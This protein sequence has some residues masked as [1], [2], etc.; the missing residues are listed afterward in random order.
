MIYLIYATTLEEQ[1]KVL[2]QREPSQDCNLCPRLV[3]F[4]ERN[5]VIYPDFHNAPV[6]TWIPDMRHGDINSGDVSKVE[7]MIIGL[8]PGLKGANCTG[9][10]F[11]G[12]FA[13][14]L[15]YETLV[16]FGFAHGEYGAHPNDGLRL[17]RTAITNAV[18]CLP[19]Q[20]KP[21][22][23]EINMCRSFLSTT[24]GQ[25]ENLRLLITL[26][27]IAHATTIR[28]LGLRVSDFPF[29][30][31]EIHDFGIYTAI[32]S[33]HCSR[34]NTQTKRLTPKMFE[35]VFSRAHRFLE[36]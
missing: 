24:I 21:I 33:Y 15:L 27:G 31:N 3:E 23:S 13:G 1:R 18:R 28:A 26:G 11:T 14:T 7:M 19:P 5:R 16:K 32:S 22:G 34:Y 36:S 10:P 9:R 29:G 17:H 6:P 12:D 8:A 35:A 20:N 25:M 30:H 2:L 4:R